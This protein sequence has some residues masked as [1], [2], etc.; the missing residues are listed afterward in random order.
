MNKATTAAF[1]LLPFLLTAC[2][3]GESQASEQSAA[4]ANTIFSTDHAEIDTNAAVLPASDINLHS[5]FSQTLSCHAG[6]KPYYQPGTSDGWL[7]SFDGDQLDLIGADQ[8]F[9]GRLS[10]SGNPIER[11]ELGQTARLQTQLGATGGQIW[12]ERDVSGR[13]ISAGHTGRSDGQEVNCGSA[14]DQAWLPML[15]T[16]PF[17][18]DADALTWTTSSEIGMHCASGTTEQLGTSRKARLQLLAGGQL[19]VSADDDGS[20]L[21]SL[22]APSSGDRSA[23]FVHESPLAGGLRVWFSRLATDEADVFEAQLRYDF[24]LLELRHRRADGSMTRCV[25]APL[26]PALN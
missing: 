11:I 4:K 9:G 3:S 25:P 21:L 6:V 15:A 7:V 19:R 1:C 17:L 23:G 5:A 24:N 18:K 22:A 13:V 10:T 14:Y 2:G 8:R 20:T 16:P 26:D 12:F